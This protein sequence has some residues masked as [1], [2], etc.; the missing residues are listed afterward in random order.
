INWQ[1]IILV[2]FVFLVIAMISS[3]LSIVK[4]AKIDPVEVINGG[5]E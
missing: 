5:G 3:A 2:S 4:V 1:N